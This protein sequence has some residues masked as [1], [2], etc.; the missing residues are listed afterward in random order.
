MRCKVARNLVAGNID[1]LGLNP[2]SSPVPTAPPNAFKG[3]NISMEYLAGEQ[4][5]LSSAMVDHGS[6]YDRHPHAALTLQ[7]KVPTNLRYLWK[8][9][10]CSK[11]FPNS[12]QEAGT[13]VF[14][15]LEQRDL[16]RRMKKLEFPAFCVG[17]IVA[18]TK[19]DQYA[20]RG[21]T[22]FVGLCILKNEFQ[23]MLRACFTLRNVILEEPLEINFFTNSPQIQK[24]EVLR[25][26]MWYEHANSLEFLRDF[27]PRFSKID[28][29]MEAEPYSVEPS[30][31]RFNTKDR[32][33]LKMWFDDDFQSRRRIGAPYMD[34]EDWH[35][36]GKAKTG[37]NGR[38]KYGYLQP[39]NV[40]INPNMI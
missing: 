39:N 25:H 27:P 12:P 30:I 28:E 32:N 7:G 21:F 10:E 33:E 18:V 3:G 6:I 23:N 5:K 19:S 11:H 15:Y 2:T 24:I 40:Y 22:R 4:L 34:R 16:Y 26:E 14:H 38:R 8:E 17:S 1:E 36:W 31:F 29:Q 13:N 35:P 20:P 9:N 37:Y